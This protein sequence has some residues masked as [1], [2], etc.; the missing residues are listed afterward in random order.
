[1]LVYISHSGLTPL[2]MMLG[3]AIYERDR[4]RSLLT[5]FNRIGACSR[6]QTIRS[7]RSLL[8]SYAVKC[9]EDGETP[10]P[11]TFTKED[12]IM[13]GMDN[14]DYADKSSISG[15]EGSNYAA[16]VVFQDATVNRP[17]S[18]PTVFITVISRA[19]PILKTKLPCPEVPPHIKPIVRPALSQDMLLHPESKQDTLLDTQSARN[20]ATN[21]D[22]FY[23]CSGQWFR[24]RKS[25]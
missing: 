7:S 1:M 8:A 15:T 18:K 19:H 22:L 20:V 9:S 12:Y 3:H 10:I 11:S 14:S 5:A 4:S 21:R 24:N 16:L 23:K 2:H 6:Y 13:A 17:N 25:S